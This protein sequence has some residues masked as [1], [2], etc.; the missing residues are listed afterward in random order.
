M[1]A[2]FGV[3]FQ[4]LAF[5]TNVLGAKILIL[6][7][8]TE[9]KQPLIKRPNLKSVWG[10]T[11]IIWKFIPYYLGYAVLIYF[12]ELKDLPGTGWTFYTVSFFLTVVVIINVIA[13][14]ILY[15]LR[16]TNR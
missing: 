15:L 13:T 7:E 4:F 3:A 9:I 14:L 1:H 10:W 2:F 12:A 5:Q 11:N 16:R 6:K 8:R